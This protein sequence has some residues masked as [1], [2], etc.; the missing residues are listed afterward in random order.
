[1]YFVLCAGGIVAPGVSC[2]LLLEAGGSGPALL[3]AANLQPQQV[4]LSLVLAYSKAHHYLSVQP[5]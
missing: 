3:Q 2:V 5:K 4:H 1:M